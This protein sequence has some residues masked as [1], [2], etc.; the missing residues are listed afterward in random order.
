MSDRVELAWQDYKIRVLDFSLCVVQTC[1]TFAAD[2]LQY[3]WTSG[4]NC[5][6][7]CCWGSGP[8]CTFQCIRTVGPNRT[9]QFCCTSGPNCWSAFLPDEWTKKQHSAILLDSTVLRNVA[10]YWLTPLLRIRKYPRS[11]LGRHDR[12]YWGLS[13]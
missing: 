2:S 11:C 10:V 13:P 3:Q 4:P 12:A 7:R 8:D 6:L 5:C 1:L 9:L